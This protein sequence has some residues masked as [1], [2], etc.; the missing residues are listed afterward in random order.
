MLEYVTILREEYSAIGD[1]DEMLCLWGGRF[2]K[3]EGKLER[4]NLLKIVTHRDSSSSSY[5]DSAMDD[6]CRFSA[7]MGPSIAT[8]NIVE[9]KNLWAMSPRGSG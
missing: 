3:S 9:R 2:I 1:G 4:S 7:W 5:T 6:L 8:Y